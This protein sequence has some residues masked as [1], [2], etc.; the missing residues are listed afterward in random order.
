MRKRSPWRRPLPKPHPMHVRRLQRPI[1]VRRLLWRVRPWELARLRR[2]L[3]RVGPWELA[4]LLRWRRPLRLRV[5]I[6]PRR[7]VRL[8]WPVHPQELTCLLRLLPTV[9]LWGWTRP[10]RPI[11]LRRPQRNP[12]LRP[13]RHH[14][15]TPD[16]VS[17]YCP[18]QNQ[19][20]PPSP[21]SRRRNSDGPLPP[22]GPS[23]RWGRRRPVAAAPSSCCSLVALRQLAALSRSSA[24][25]ADWPSTPPGVST[26]AGAPAARIA[27]TTSSGSILPLP[28]LS[29]RSRPESKP[30]FES[31]A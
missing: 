2:L 9:H 10:S 25:S 6:R 18:R 8:L 24:M 31:F 14:P 1:H 16:R 28:R 22:A 20:R 19:L 21:T 17:T 4:R 12:P 23:P 7:L 13:R 3:R 30:S 29:C 15:P 26:I 5:L 11:R 27:A